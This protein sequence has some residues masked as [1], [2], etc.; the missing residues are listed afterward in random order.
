MKLPE[1]LEPSVTGPAAAPVS[2]NP[3]LL[4][5]GEKVRLLRSRKGMTRRMLAKSS[6]VSERHLANLELGVGNASVVLLA[7]VA[8]ALD[9]ALTDLL[10]DAATSSPERLLIGALLQDRSEDDL[11]RGRKALAALYGQPGSSGARVRRV[12]LVGLRGAGKSTLGRML[13]Q[14]LA[15]PF[16]ELTR[17]VERVAGC[18]LAEIQNLLGQAAY[19]RYEKRALQ[20]V[21]A[22]RADAVIAT[23]GGI[24]SDPATFNL[25]LSECLTVWLQASPTEHMQRVVTQGDLR[26]MAGNREAM[27]DLERIL[28]SRAPLYG[29]ADIRVNTSA[30][31]LAANFAQLRKAV[32]GAREAQRHDLPATA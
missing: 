10:S 17:E 3:L 15:V 32:R 24:V 7:Q 6:S 11:T 23:P 5:L 4:A 14:A 8:R 9:C 25:L 28:A 30:R 18:S 21:L 29:K 16:V 13:A 31:T 22:L 26:P 20:E 19:R 27:D 2:A 1:L 12:A